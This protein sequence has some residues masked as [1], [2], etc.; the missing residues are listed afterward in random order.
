MEQAIK[1]FAEKVGVKPLQCACDTCSNEFFPTHLKQKFCSTNCSVLTAVRRH[2]ESIPSAISR[3]VEPA[4]A[5]DRQCLYCKETLL[6]VTIANAERMLEISK[7]YL[8]DPKDR[9]VTWGSMRRMHN[10]FC[11][12]ACRKDNGTGT[13]SNW[14][15]SLES[16]ELMENEMRQSGV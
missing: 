3:W 13:H 14:C 16:V 8:P 4:E 9:K 10:N 2:R 11:C 1:E 7:T 12:H 5:P 6:K 15:C